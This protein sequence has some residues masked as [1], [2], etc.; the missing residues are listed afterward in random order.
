M[1]GPRKVWLLV[2]QGCWLQFVSSCA[3]RRNKKKEIRFRVSLSP[4]SF[5]FSYLVIEGETRGTKSGK[6]NNDWQQRVY[7]SSTEG[8]SSIT[9]VRSPCDPHMEEVCVPSQVREAVFP[10]RSL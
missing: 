6:S 7:I 1:L 2:V 9:H 4:L 5:S 10:F 3:Q 8:L